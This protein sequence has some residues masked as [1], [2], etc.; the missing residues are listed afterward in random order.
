VQA[1]DGAALP[2]GSLT[3]AL[4]AGRVL[5]AYQWE[6]A[7]PVP[8][9]SDV[10]PEHITF[11]ERG[12]TAKT[13]L[14]LSFPADLDRD[15]AR[16]GA[17][18]S[19]AGRGLTSVPG[20][21]GT[22]AHLAPASSLTCELPPAA[23][24][25]R[26]WTLEFWIRT[27]EPRAADLVTVPGLLSVRCNRAGN[28]RVELPEA[29]T[30]AGGPRGVTV[31]NPRLL[32]PGSWHH[33]GVVLD[34]VDLQA[35][36]LVVDDAVQG[37]RLDAVSVSA[38][39]AQ[40][41]LGAAGDEPRGFAGTLDDVRLVSLNL[42][43]SELFAHGSLEREPVERLRLLYAATGGEPEVEELELWKHVQTDPR[44]EGAE[45]WS[46]GALVHAFA[47]ADGLGW[48]PE[49]WRTVGGEERPVARTT[50]AVTAIGDRRVLVFGGETR[51]SHFGRGP[52]TDDTWIFD[53]ADESWT[54]IDT[55]V[56]PSR[57]C[58]MPAAYSPDHRAALLVGGWFQGGW[59]TGAGPEKRFTDTW[60]YRV[61]EAR[62]EPRK[63]SGPMMI[64]DNGLV[65]LP[66]ERRF[67]VLM[68]GR[69]SYY[70]PD[71]DTWDLRRVTQFEADGELDEGP[72]PHSRTAVLDPES[73]R[74]YLFGGVRK[75]DEYL[76]ATAYFDPQTDE[77]HALAPPVRPAPRVRPAVSY[78]PARKRF[79]LFG[80]VRDQRSDRFDDL[81]TFDPATGLW[82]E[83]PRQAQRP[84]ARGGYFGFAY[85]PGAD[86][87]VLSSGRNAF[88]R[89][90]DD[91]LVL[92][93]DETRSGS[94]RYVFDRA[95]FGD[96]VAWYAETTTPGDSAVRFRFRP[97][98]DGLRFGAWSDTCPAG[99][100]FVQVEVVLQPGTQ[101]TPPSV[102]A[103]GF[104]PPT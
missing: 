95:D 26:V 99:T 43:S 31:Q 5:D 4:A 91:T 82:S 46:R 45:E 62:W 103:M 11:G 36:R 7:G 104:R 51:D 68:P 58:H 32:V 37:S 28:V 33:V 12:R 6:G 83:V 77:I 94:A 89:W 70:S 90:M 8:W 100:R 21:F 64:H 14:Y 2:P 80:G 44:L 1:G 84:V 15:L 48:T 92:D 76:D 30:D 57:R 69:A 63:P 35:V 93:L 55:P 38:P 16:Q 72:A 96:A 53:G 71:T 97:S 56:A 81:W 20:R 87:F 74:V 39:L 79:V 34:L 88:E 29:A 101:G 73:G 10:P 59:W 3:P 65:Y 60:L 22:G 19:V 17:G 18:C 54:R 86:G 85:D 23:R 67:L 66:R 24:D 41:V 78:D 52:N 27:D 40:L 50:H 75:D 102:R 9:G 61:D 25:L 13:L 42:S 47:S 98:E 49:S